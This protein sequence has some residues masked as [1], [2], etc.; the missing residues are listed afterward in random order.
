[1]AA[2]IDANLLIAY[3]FKSDQ[4]HET[5][6]SLFQGLVR[7]GERLIVPTPVLA[8][9][10]YH[11]H[12]RIHYGRAIQVF[13]VTH[14]AY[15]VETPTLADRNRMM[16]IMSKYKDSEFDYTDMAIMAIAERLLIKKICTID[17]DFTYYRPKHCSNF[18]VLPQL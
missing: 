4:Y 17:D 8:E 6:Q 16:A 1:M 3:Y 5:A 14:R 12:K 13:E 10:F 11:I 18:E 7:Q 15:V 2:I 9:T